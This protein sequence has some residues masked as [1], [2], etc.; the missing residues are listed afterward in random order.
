MSGGIVRRCALAASCRSHNNISKAIRE[1]EGDGKGDVHRPVLRARHMRDANGKVRQ[2]V[3]AISLHPTSRLILRNPLLNAI[4]RRLARA[5]HVLA[6]RPHA[7]LLLLIPDDPQR[8]AREARTL[9][10]PRV[11]ARHEGHER[12][13]VHHGV[14]RGFPRRGVCAGR[15][16]DRPAAV[17][18][19][20]EVG[21]AEDGRRARRER[22]QCVIQHGPVCGGRVERDDV[23][24]HDGV[25]DAVDHGVDAH[26]EDVLVVLCGDAGGDGGG[27]GRGGGRG[28]VFDG[29]LDDAGETELELDVAVLVESVVEDV[30]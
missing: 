14:P 22:V 12:A 23:G 10:D 16:D 7:R 11:V 19:K 8:P 15:V 21:R 13:L 9:R 24:L 30:F 26:G 5:G 3:L 1:G 20:V 4:R 27:E 28:R 25:V 6:R 17:C 2:H 18:R 29:D